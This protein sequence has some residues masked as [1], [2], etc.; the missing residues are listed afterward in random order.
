MKVLL[1]LSNWFDI[2]RY[3]FILNHLTYI[4]SIFFLFC[5]LEN[6]KGNLFGF[7]FLN[8]YYYFICNLFSRNISYICK[9][10]TF[11]YI[12]FVYNS[13]IFFSY[14]MNRIYVS[15][16]FNFLFHQLQIIVLPYDN[17]L[18]YLFLWIVLF[19]SYPLLTLYLINKY[20]FYTPLPLVYFI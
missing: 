12:I 13:I 14:I 18:P 5:Q 2:I 16:L 1:E 7:L 6:K 15:K 10:W 11:T 4:I 17:Q 8:F 19:L 9:S 20:S 3:W